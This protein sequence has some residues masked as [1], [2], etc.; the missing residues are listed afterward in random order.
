LS[1]NAYKQLVAKEITVEQYNNIHIK[2]ETIFAQAIEINRE[3]S[4]LT[5]GL[6]EADLNGIDTATKKLTE[7][8]KQIKKI[9]DIVSVSIKLIV[10]IGVTATAVAAPN[11]SSIL[12]ALESAKD[13]ADDIIK[14][15]EASSEAPT[16]AE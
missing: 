16:P 1:I 9:K 13:V 15:A 14:M 12:A 8:A 3:V 7:A 6:I 11:P 5:E 2:V 4:K 10:L